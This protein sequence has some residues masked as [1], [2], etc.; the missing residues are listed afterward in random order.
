MTKTFF[1]YITQHEN[2]KNYNNINEIKIYHFK[3]IYNFLF[4]PKSNKIKL[5]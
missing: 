2:S 5:V 3:Y 1:K 4:N